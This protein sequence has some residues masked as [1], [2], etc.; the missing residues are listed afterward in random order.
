MKK[1]SIFTL[2]AFMAILTAMIAC[3]DQA[4][5]QPTTPPELPP[6]SSMSSDMGN[7]SSNEEKSTTV[8]GVSN[9]QFAAGN[10]IFW[11]SFLAVDLAIPVAAFNE[12][13]NHN[14]EY[15]KTD[16]QWKSEYSVSVANQEISA[17]LYAKRSDNNN[18]VMWKMYLSSEG[19]F[20]DFLW[21]EGESNINNTGGFWTL[22][23]SPSAPRP[24]LRIN[25]DR[26]D[27]EAVSSTYTLVDVNSDKEGSSIAYGLSSENGFTHRY[28][29]TIES[30]NQ[31]GY[32]LSILYNQETRVGKVK[33]E[34]HY[35][36]NIWHCWNE[37]LE[38]TNCE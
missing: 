23:K 7:F 16:Q 24:V 20:D 37:N 4:D 17:T 34:T 2:C 10:V 18:K 33:S 12:A 35:N 21:F 14:F 22:Y 6:K 28:A 11:Q 1:F 15:L 8:N 13:F 25:W 26:I 32:D 31:E 27:G 30:K 38:D 29:V 36:D 3:S 9:F 5:E 19:K